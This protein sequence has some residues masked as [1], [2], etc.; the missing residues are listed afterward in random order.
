MVKGE[1]TPNRPFLHTHWAFLCVCSPAPYKLP[2]A[3]TQAGQVVLKVRPLLAFSA[4]PEPSAPRA[5]S[6]FLLFTLLR[7]LSVGH[8]RAAT[9]CF[10]PFPV[11]TGT[12]LVSRTA[13]RC[14]SGVCPVHPRCPLQGGCWGF[15]QSCPPC[16]R[17][18]GHSRHRLR[19]SHR[20]DSLGTV[21]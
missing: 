21:A 4:L 9:C 7:R 18:H 13:P 1:R 12:V 6:I 8:S 20:G 3:V 2:K 19:C 5:G 17:A 14:V 15:A 11:S 16:P 10:S